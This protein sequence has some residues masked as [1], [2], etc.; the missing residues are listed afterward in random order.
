MGQEML[1]VSSVADKS[2]NSPPIGGFKQ[3]E[4]PN[5]LRST[6]MQ[7]SCMGN[8]ALSSG[9]LGMS[10]IN[11]CSN[12]IEKRC[13]EA[14]EIMRKALVAPENQ[15]LIYDALLRC[16]L[17][18]IKK[19]T[20]IAQDESEKGV[21]SL[22]QFL[23]LLEE[24]SKA[25]S[26]SKTARERLQEKIQKKEKELQEKKKAAEGE[27]LRKKKEREEYEEQLEN[28]KEELK[29]ASDALPTPW[30]MLSAAARA[31]LSTRHT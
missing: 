10:T 15:A 18:N 9:L 19:T 17:E 20:K 31:G 4:H 24:T 23:D 5:S 28:I 21:K 27:K 8:K 1:T 2:I 3:I 13:M 6:L 14:E 25:C 16:N 22:E 26:D 11:I 29:K 7:I 12:A 30:A